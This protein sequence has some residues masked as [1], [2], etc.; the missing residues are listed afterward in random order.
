MTAQDLKQRTKNVRGR[1]EM[2]NQVQKGHG[3]EPD[4]VGEL[5]HHPKEQ[6]RKRLS[7]K[8]DPVRKKGD[9]EKTT[10]KKSE[11]ETTLGICPRQTKLKGAR[12]GSNSRGNG[13]KIKGAK[14]VAGPGRGKK[15]GQEPD[16][17]EK[18]EIGKKVRR[19]SVV[20][21]EVTYCKQGEKQ[22]ESTRSP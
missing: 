7:L 1:G 16:V 12:S 4:R 5:P 17:S 8:K 9:G 21:K 18:S 13:D 14:T 6:R 19:N 11:K 3:S 22:P 20:E 10:K 2:T 15:S